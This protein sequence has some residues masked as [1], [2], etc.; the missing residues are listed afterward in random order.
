MDYVIFKTGGKQYRV[1]K[2]S[3]VDIEKIDGDTGASVS[4]DEVLAVSTGGSLNVGAPVVSGASV[5]AEIIDQYRAK[6]LIAYK[7]KRR[8]GYHRKVGHRQPQTRIKI[9]GF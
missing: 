1:E 3:I 4:F 6:K 2:N 9:T 5:K 8:K 7:Q